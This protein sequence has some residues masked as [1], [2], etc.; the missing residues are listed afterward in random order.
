MHVTLLD[1]AFEGYRSEIHALLDEIDTFTQDIGNQA[2]TEV[3][4]GLTFNVD[5]PFLFVIVGE[6]K[7]GKSSFIN[8]LLGHEVCVIAY[9]TKYRVKI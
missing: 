5:E 1:L 9:V 8:A 6:I 2:L 3:V 4:E 7:S